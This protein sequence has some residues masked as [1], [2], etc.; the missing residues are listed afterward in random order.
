[1]TLK[2]SLF[3]LVVR[4]LDFGGL[5]SNDALMIFDYSSVTFLI[6]LHVRY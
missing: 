2:A 4:E 5:E 3:F 6:L 1:M